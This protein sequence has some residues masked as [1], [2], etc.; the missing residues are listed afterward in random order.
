MAKI[1]TG[2]ILGMVATLSMLVAAI[3]ILLPPIHLIILILIAGLVGVIFTSFI[4]IL[5]DLNFP[6][7]NWDNEQKAVK[8]NMNLMISILI[9]S[10]VSAVVVIPVIIFHLNVWLVL[11]GLVLIFGFANAVLYGLIKSAGVSLFEKI[12][13]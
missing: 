11:A 7:L 13:A 10:V 4:G 3:F 5:I 12:E 6:K 2:I 8:Q 9:S 1:M